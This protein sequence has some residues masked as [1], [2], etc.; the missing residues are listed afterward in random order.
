VQPTD[1]PI[2]PETYRPY[3]LLFI[4][5]VTTDEMIKHKTAVTGIPTTGFINAQEI[6]IFDRRVKTKT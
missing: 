2:Y 4:R 5:Y 3:L 1:T 6:P